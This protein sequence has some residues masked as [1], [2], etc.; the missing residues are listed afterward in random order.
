[1]NELRKRLGDKRVIA[2]L[3]FGIVAFLWLRSRGASA[4]TS[5]STLPVDPTTGQLPADASATGFGPGLT[6]DDLTPIQASLEGVGTGIGTGF[7]DLAAQLAQTEADLAGQIQGAFVATQNANDANQLQG[8][9]SSPS[10]QTEILTTPIQ[11]STTSTSTTPVATPATAGAPPGIPAVFTIGGGLDPAIAAAYA[12]RNKPVAFS[13]DSILPRA[14]QPPMPIPTNESPAPAP[15]PLTIAGGLDPAI[16]AAVAAATPAPAPAP[17][18]PPPPPA[19]L[20][21]HLAHG[22]DPGY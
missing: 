5:T 6:P 8:P 12:A 19:L 2:A 10:P 7:G 11:P 1:V 22:R 17:P 18:P 14:T 20:A 13:F 4:V 3:G 15:P 9:F 21:L 16:A